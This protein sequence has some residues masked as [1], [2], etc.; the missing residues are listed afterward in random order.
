MNIFFHKT[1]LLLTVL[2][3]A[4]CVNYEEKYKTE[5]QQ[6]DSL[7][8]RVEILEKDLISRST[9]SKELEKGEKQLIE[10]L[11][12]I[13]PDTVDEETAEKLNEFNYIVSLKTSL[14]DTSSYYAEETIK[15]HKRLGD[16][17]SDLKIGNVEENKI[18]EYIQ[19]EKTKI[20][21]II[22]SIQLF[23]SLMLRKPLIFDWASKQVSQAK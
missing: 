20:Q 8:S 10:A 18:Q 9:A 19:G 11:S 16:L 1:A 3:Q 4:A 15:L 2:S 13:L 23:D 21:N 6:I 22:N 5:I 17:S 12:R 7:K 14:S